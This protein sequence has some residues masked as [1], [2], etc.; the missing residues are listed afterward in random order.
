MHCHCMDMLCINVN[1][2]YNFYDRYKTCACF[3][4]MPRTFQDASGAVTAP[5]KHFL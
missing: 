5:N 4:R 1:K 2:K 3:T